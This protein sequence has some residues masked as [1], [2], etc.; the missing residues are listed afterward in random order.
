MPTYEATDDFIRDL[1]RLTREQRLAFRRAVGRFV[2]DTRSGK[3]RSGL[4][5][6]GIQGRPGSFEMTWA[7]NGRAILTY[8]PAV[9]SGETHIVWLAVGTHEILP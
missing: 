2:E 1:G 6:K 9:L 7:D 3:F 5:V 8:G 4:R